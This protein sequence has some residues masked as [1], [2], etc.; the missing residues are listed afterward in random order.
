MTAY[1]LLESHQ[2]KTPPSWRDIVFNFNTLASA[3]LRKMGLPEKYT[4]GFT[5]ATLV[6]E[7]KYY[8]AWLTDELTKK[9]V[10][11]EQ[12]KLGS[13]DELEGYDAVVNC[14][15]IG[16]VLNTLFTAKLLIFNK[17]AYQENVNKKY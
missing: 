1:I 3:D 7:Q 6:I 5:F 8:M 17:K 10:T 13:L 16:A 11:F 14:C 9:G 4:D 2:D 15:G 12:R